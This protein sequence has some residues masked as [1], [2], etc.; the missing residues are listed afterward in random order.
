LTG[1]I[2]YLAE[3]LETIRRGWNRFFFEPADPTSLGLI[4]LFTGILAFWSLLVFGLDLNDYFS[5]TGWSDPEV[6]R[7]FQGQRQPL[8][9]SFW[10]W[11]PDGWLRATWL[12]CLAIL[13]LFA[14]G[15]SSRITAV[16]SWI[17][18]VSTVRRVPNALF[19]FDQ[20]LSLLTLY[21]AATGA[22]GQAVSLDRFIRRYQQARRIARIPAS[23]RGPGLTILPE[24]PSV[25]RPTVAANL[26]LRL[27][28]LHLVL[29][30]GMAGL[31]KLQGPSWWNGMAIWGTLTAGEFV[32][33]NFTA[34]ATW[35]LILNLL[36]HGSLLL[37]LSYPI[38]IWVRI[39]RPL[40]LAGAVLLHLGIAVMSP[41]LAE[42][43]LAM[44]AGNL[45]FVSGTWL[46]TLVIDRNKYP[47]RVL[48]DGRCP[49]C[50]ASL[51]WLTAADPDHVLDPLDL[52]A[53]DVRA[54]HPS[55]SPEACVRSMHVVTQ[56]GQ[57]KVG[58]DAVRHVLC[59]VPLFKPLGVMGSLPGVAWAGNRVYD[60]LAATRPR[61]AICT[62]EVCEVAPSPKATRRAQRS[63]SPSESAT[64]SPSQD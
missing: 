42:F 34:L 3:L 14:A 45:A 55:L 43:G 24:D 44:L 32:S 30:Y 37:E 54:V 15:W 26:G 58:F 6:V 51:A 2:A 16:L 53:V 59:S 5:S 8:A 61:D 4:R 18:V 33:F 60:R 29:I 20:I 1:T 48:Y 36:T 10:F 38:L 49:R 11:V 7:F 47:L 21:L 40:M 64:S 63:G 57:V 50:R 56:K 19:G 12:G 41:G 27:I 28:Q 9:W 52:N 23:K 25:P 35:P 62:D 17:I 39:A 46:R 13:A 31:A 22:S